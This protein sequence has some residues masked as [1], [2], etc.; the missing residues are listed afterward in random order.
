[1]LLISNVNNNVNNNVYNKN[2]LDMIVE[3][4]SK[5]AATIFAL[6]NDDVKYL[7]GE[8]RSYIHKSEDHIHE[9]Q[10]DG[11]VVITF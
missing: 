10:G 6:S 3:I 11:D 2:P 7:I 9:N 4:K 5:Y 8:I 1:M